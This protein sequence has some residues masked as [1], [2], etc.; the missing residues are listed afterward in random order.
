MRVIGKA[1][2]L[3]VLFAAMLSSSVFADYIYDIVDFC[4]CE[5]YFSVFLL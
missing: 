3:V 2:I 1:F 4:P 5:L